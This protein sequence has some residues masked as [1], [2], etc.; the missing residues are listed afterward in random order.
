MRRCWPGT[1]DLAEQDIYRV[2]ADRPDRPEGAAGQRPA[3]AVLPPWRPL[4]APVL[5]DADPW[6][7]LRRRDVLLHHPFE[8]FDHVLGLLQAAAGDD[9]VLAI[10]MTLYRT[11]GDSPV[12]QA[13]ERAAAN[14]KQVTALV[15]IKARFDEQQNIDWAAPAWSA[16]GPSWCMAS[17][18]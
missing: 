3:R 6:L 4:P 7:V 15:E 17:P 13:L 2:S 9:A 8:T 11:S 10:K 12:V 5:A 1:W 18:G 14:G 16:P